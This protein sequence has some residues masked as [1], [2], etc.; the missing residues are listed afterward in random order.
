M[1]GYQLVLLLLPLLP[2]KLVINEVVSHTD[3]PYFDYV[4]LLNTGPDEISL[5]GWMVSEARTE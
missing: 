3:S 5:E 2:C 1:L 4:E